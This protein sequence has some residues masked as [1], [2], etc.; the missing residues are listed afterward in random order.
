MLAAT[1]ITASTLSTRLRFR[2]D[3]PAEW[4]VIAVP[5]SLRGRVALPQR[6][7]WLPARPLA[8]GAPYDEARGMATLFAREP[9]RYVTIRAVT[10]SLRARRATPTG[11][12]CVDTFGG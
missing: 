4:C 5:P 3:L 12:G 11:T 6:P 10:K 9:P 2:P 1:R 7:A 8:S